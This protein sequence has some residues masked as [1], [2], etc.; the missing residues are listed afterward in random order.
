MLFHL[1]V[2]KFWPHKCSF[3]C[4]FFWI[5]WTAFFKLAHFKTQLQQRQEVFA[6][7]KQCVSADISWFHCSRRQAAGKYNSWAPKRWLSESCHN[8]LIQLKA[9]VRQRA[10][11]EDLH[12]NVFT[13]LRNYWCMCLSFDAH[14]ACCVQL[15]S[16]AFIFSNHACV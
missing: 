15:T 6:C 3:C 2:Y 10:Q 9:L 14:S 13:Q 4:I 12:S 5:Q 11:S 16:N 7:R 8:N 1:L